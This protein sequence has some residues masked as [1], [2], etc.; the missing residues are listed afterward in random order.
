MM[1]KAGIAIILFFTL[2]GKSFANCDLT[3]FRWECDLPAHANPH[4]SS[5]SLVYCGNTRVYINQA[6]YEILTRYQR[7]N[8]NMVLKVNGEYVDSP[9][10]PAERYMSY[11]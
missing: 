7:A 8:V 9:C 3:R 11:P 2:L 5:Y 1:G 4:P 10:V 6:E